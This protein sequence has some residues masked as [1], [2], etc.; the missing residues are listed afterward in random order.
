MQ[1]TEG[2]SFHSWLLSGDETRSE[3]D[4]LLPVVTDCTDPLKGGWSSQD[5]S[6]YLSL[7]LPGS[8]V[9]IK[10]GT[11]KLSGSCS[12]PETC[13]PGTQELHETLDS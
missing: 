3:A 8:L 13:F 9:A 7:H 10:K 2:L 5:V 4:L 6:E 12:S 1:K 11:E